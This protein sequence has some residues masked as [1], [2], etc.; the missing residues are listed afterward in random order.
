M[1]SILLFVAIQT[2]NAQV[3]PVV[4]RRSPTDQVQ[5]VRVAPR[6][7]T[8]IRVP[9]PVS[10]LVIGDPERFLAEHSEKEPTLVLVK[11]VTEQ[12]GESNLLVVT[13]SGRQLSFLLRM[14][15]TGPKRV[16]FVLVYK[17]A[18]SFLVGES[19]PA[20][21]EVAGTHVLRP[22]SGLAIPK[23]VDAEKVVDPLQGILNRQKLAPLP[24]CTE[25]SLQRCLARAI[26][27][28]PASPKSSIKGA[29]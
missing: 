1:R 6:F 18:G 3:E 16:D 29:R 19:F 9:E 27:F 26:G 15:P 13:T 11:P 28:E 4:S 22:V 14:D 25:A 12:P 20:S 2:L 10:S 7:A 23:A 5:V 24:P 8:A 21:A 17:S